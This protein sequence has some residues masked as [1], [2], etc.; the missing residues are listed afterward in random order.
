MK[1]QS[2]KTQKIL[3]ALL[4]LIVAVPFIFMLT[5]CYDLVFG[6]PSSNNP[7]PPIGDINNGTATPELPIPQLEFDSDTNTLTICMPMPRYIA[8][9]VPRGV[10]LYIN[11]TRFNSFIQGGSGVMTID[12]KEFLAPLNLSDTTH[13][14]KARAINFVNDSSY[15]SFLS[16]PVNF[17]I[18]NNPIFRPPVI[19][20]N[21][22]TP[23]VSFN[24]NNGFIS[25]S[26]P[27]GLML[28]GPPNI[29][30]FIYVNARRVFYRLN[31]WQHEFALIPF[32]NQNALVCTCDEVIVQVRAVACVPFEMVSALS[33]KILL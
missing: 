10:F 7:Q 1:I 24:Q 5:A 20:Y 13:Q 6:M 22:P 8:S 29:G 21:L 16:E 14:V 2:S 33:E 32:L 23:I 28:A 30:F 3:I 27:D 9:V 12:L 17:K 25:I 31:G 19:E 11:G 15:V 26:L 18:N 4:C